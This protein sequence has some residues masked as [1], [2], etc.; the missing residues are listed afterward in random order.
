MPLAV[1]CPCCLVVDKRG[2]YRNSSAAVLDLVSIL[3]LVALDAAT[4][5]PHGGEIS[6]EAYLA[7]YYS[8]AFKSTVESN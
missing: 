1:W 3:V 6:C 5:E 8:I 2:F 4:S 7:N